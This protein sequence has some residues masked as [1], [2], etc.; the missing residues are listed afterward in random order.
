MRP[1]SSL[2]APCFLHL[3]GFAVSEPGSEPD[4]C[5]EDIEDARL[6]GPEFVGRDGASSIAHLVPAIG[7]A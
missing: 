4:M 7:S 2:N 1:D 3:Q 5:G 6:L